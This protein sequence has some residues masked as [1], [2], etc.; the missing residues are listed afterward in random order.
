MYKNL[1]N[2]P[3]EDRI[4]EIIL[5]AVQ[6][7]KEFIT[8]SLS[9]ELIGMNKDLMTQYISYVA[10]RLLLMLGLSKI[11]NMTNPFDWMEMIA[12]SRENKFFLKKE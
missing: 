3:I 12:H 7:E 5:D 9:C 6:I 2:K 4:K 1:K 10:D 11:F 8:E